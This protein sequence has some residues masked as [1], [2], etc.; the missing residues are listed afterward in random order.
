MPFVKETVEMKRE[1]FVKAAEGRKKTISALCREYGIS[2]PTGYL[3]IERYR[4]GE[5][6]RDRSKAPF[7]TANKTREGMEKKIVEAR[8]KEPAIGAVKIRQMLKN[9]GE[10]GLPCASTINAILKRNELITRESS[11]AAT[12]Y[13]RFEKPKPNIMWQCDFKGH[14]A[15]RDGARCHPLSIIDDHSRYCLC[16]DAKADEQYQGVAESFA[17]CFDEYGLPDMLLCDN[18]HPW[19][20]SRATGVTKFEVQLMEHGILPI[21][22]RA[23]HPQTQG[24]VEKFN[25]SFKAERLEYYTPADIAEADRQRQEY[26]QFYNEVRPHHALQ[27]DTPAMRYTPSSRKYTTNIEDWDYGME[28]EKRIIKSTGYLTYGGR[29]YFLSE[30]YGR[31]TIAI[32]PSSIDGYVNLYFR[33]FK[34]GRLDLREHCIVSRK[35]YLSEGD[36]RAEPNL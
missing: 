21:H 26:R 28:C 24:K 8:L 17:R 23:M 3:W 25:G 19:G 16:A 6:Y 20:T 2:R 12:P 36:P 18:G 5:G 9:S 11:Q 34:I 14:Y 31:K 27:L 13:K 1:E 22:I 10:T 7:K 15:L 32:K 30:A 33:Q 4:N 29:T 35:I